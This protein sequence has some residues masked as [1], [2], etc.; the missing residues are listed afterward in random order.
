MSRRDGAVASTSTVSAP[1]VDPDEILNPRV[2]DLLRGREVRVRGAP[3]MKQRLSNKLWK[4]V[5]LAILACVLWALQGRQM[6]RMNAWADG[7]S[8]AAGEE[9][10]AK[11]F[12][13][14]GAFGGNGARIVH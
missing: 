12:S 10:V 8:R 5:V 6:A 1:V 11:R 9:S 7:D 3:M 2:R 13:K 4:L 14:R